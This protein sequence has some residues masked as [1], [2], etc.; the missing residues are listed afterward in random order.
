MSTVLLLVL[1]NCLMTFT[2]YR[3]SR[4]VMWPELAETA[5]PPVKFEFASQDLHSIFLSYPGSRHG[6]TM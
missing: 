1:S 6:T 4:Y 2:L 3:H 5:Q